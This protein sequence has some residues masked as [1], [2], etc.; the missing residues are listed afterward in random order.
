MGLK[1]ISL[2]MDA[3]YLHVLFGFKRQSLKMF[4]LWPNQEVTVPSDIINLS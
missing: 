4:N 1:K 3:D 2:Q